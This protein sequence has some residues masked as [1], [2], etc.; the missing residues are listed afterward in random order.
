MK[1]KQIKHESYQDA[2]SI[3]QYLQQ[4]LDGLEQ[5]KLSLSS[6]DD[7]LMLEPHGLMRFTLSAYQ[8]KAKHQI[9]ITLDW[10]PKNAPT[11][12]EVDDLI[13]E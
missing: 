13:I 6:G 5:G 10:T 11:I 2:E 4:V 3:K 9:R 8:S 7:S 12:A 1:K